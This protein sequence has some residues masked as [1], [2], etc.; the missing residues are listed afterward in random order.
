MNTI[1]RTTLFV[2]GIILLNQIPASCKTTEP[3][4]DEKLKLSISIPAEG[5]SWVVNDWN[6]NNELIGEDGIKNWTEQET[7]IRTYFKAEQTGKL[8]VG[9]L[10]KSVSGN[11]TLKITCGNK[12]ELI[13]VSS[14]GLSFYRNSGC[15]EVR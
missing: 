7:I 13:G 6:K 10:A 9:I 12:S 1:I 8:N 5:N 14:I 11:S 2:F 4:E 3:V 15:K